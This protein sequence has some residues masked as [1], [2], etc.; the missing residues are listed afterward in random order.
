[1][2]LRS[3]G[4]I[5]LVGIGYLGGAHVTSETLA[6]IRSAD[7]LFFLVGDPLLEIWLRS[8]NPTATSLE[9]CASEGM[10]LADCCHRM[11]D[12]VLN[13]MP[14]D[15]SICVAFSGHPGIAVD[16]AYE[17][18]QRARAARIRVTMFPAVSAIDCFFA[19]LGIDPAQGCQLF[20]TE[21]LIEMDYR[22]DPRSSLILLQAGVIGVRRHT[23]KTSAEAA[24]VRRLT[25]FLR[26]YYPSG[27]ELIVYEAATFPISPP[28]MERTTLHRLPKT[29]LT[30][31][32]TVYVPPSFE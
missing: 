30:A 24:G 3:S 9:D 22:L 6:L 20:E 32:S 16:P 15:S 27:H 26:K 5:S 7:R 23:T 19:D 2:S 17:I 1:M 29:P 25:R 4:S 8:L 10:A 11:A 28:R 31:I 18:L 14:G 12:E 21:T 13:A